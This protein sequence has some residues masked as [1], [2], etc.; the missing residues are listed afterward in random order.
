M[1]QGLHLGI[2]NEK[3]DGFPATL[4]IA[5]FIVIGLFFHF[6]TV[7]DLADLLI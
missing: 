5:G 6:G 3:I 1:S 2:K 7:A 4:P